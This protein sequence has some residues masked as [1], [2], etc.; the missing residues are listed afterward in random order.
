[1]AMEAHRISLPAVLLLFV[2]VSPTAA[3]EA[4][5]QLWSGVFARDIRPESA[6]DYSVEYQVR[7]KED[8]SALKVHYFELY[9]LYKAGHGVTAYSGYRFSIR[10]ARHEQRLFAGLFY[11]HALRKEGKEPENRRLVLTH[12]FMAQRDFNAKYNNVLLDS[13]T[14]RYAMYFERRVSH[15][16]VPTLIVGG[17][18]TWNSEFTGVD[19]LRAAAGVRYI[20]NNGDRIQML[21]VREKSMAMEPHRHA[22]IIWLRYE[23]MF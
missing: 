18:Y 15:H 21:F 2:V 23:V 19:L 1:M 7:L 22:N 17:I 10:P 12:Q 6:F 14:V 20:R 16:W 9:A 11:R 3:G 13:S 4:D 5:W 8:M